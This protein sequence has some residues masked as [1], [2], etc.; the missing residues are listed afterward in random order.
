MQILCFFL[1]LFKGSSKCGFSTL[2]SC[3]GFI[4][5]SL[6]ASC[7]FIWTNKDDDDE[8]LKCMGNTAVKVF[9][10]L[11]QK[12]YETGKWPADFL[13]T[14]IIPLEKKPNATE[15]NDFRTISLLRHA[16]KVLIRVLTK[17]IEAKANVI[18]HIGKD[19]FGFRKGK[20]TRDAIATL[21]V[22][23]ERSLQR[24]KDLRICFVDYEK[25][26]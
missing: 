9:I 8:L 4:I 10:H 21:R 2:L 17:H 11:C 25:A 13:Q 6:L 22:L 14:V 20:G 26:E 16:A 15:C 1:F 24:W 23:G 18:N 19:Q 12:L 7:I 3:S 5:C